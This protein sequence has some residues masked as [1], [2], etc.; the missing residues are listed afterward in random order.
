VTGRQVR[1][2]QVQ[3][4]RSRLST[5]PGEIGSATNT[6]NDLDTITFNTTGTGLQFAVL[7]DHT[8]GS[9]IM[10]ATIATARHERVDATHSPSGQPPLTDGFNLIIAEGTHETI[11]PP[12]DN[13]TEVG[14]G[15]G[16]IL[17]GGGPGDNFVFETLKASRPSHP[18]QIIGFKHP[19]HHDLIDL[20]DL[21]LAVSGD[22]PLRF[23]GGQTFAHYHHNHHSVFGMVRY[24]QGLVEVNVNHHLTN[25]FEIVMHGTPGAARGRLHPVAHLRSLR[26]SLV[27]RRPPAASGEP[28]SG[29]RYRA[30]LCAGRLQGS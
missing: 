18:D 28:H 1:F 21:R 25:E 23:I 22:Q 20:Y 12:G 19:L 30:L 6:F 3:Q 13:N 5:R 15:R 10:L 14:R 16:D 11:K 24:S 7:G 9:R 2:W 27:P 26:R 8:G 4:R 17:V 29:R